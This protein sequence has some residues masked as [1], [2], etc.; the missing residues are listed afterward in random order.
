MV[1]T[2]LY[3]IVALT[4]TLSMLMSSVAFASTE[5]LSNVSNSKNYSCTYVQGDKDS[6]NFKD[7][8]YSIVTGLSMAKA[9]AVVKVAITVKSDLQSLVSS[10][11]ITQAQENTIIKLVISSKNE[12]QQK[13]KIELR[14]KLN[15]LVTVGTITQTQEDSIIKV[16]SKIKAEIKDLVTSGTITQAQENT[17]I[18]LLTHYKNRDFGNGNSKD[19][20]NKD[21]LNKDN[22]ADKGNTDNNEDS[23]TS[24]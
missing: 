2:K 10:G 7:K 23:K 20:G 18:K 15:N 24:E 5:P 11:T 12:D 4:M 3:K 16:G 21:N 6:F 8:L 17:I 22:N 1:K 9:Y 13:A 19:N 14:T